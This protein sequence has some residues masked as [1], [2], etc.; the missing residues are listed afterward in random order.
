MIIVNYKGIENE[1]DH[2][3]DVREFIEEKLTKVF[4]HCFK[5]KGIDDNFCLMIQED[6]ELF[7]EEEKFSFDWHS[8]CEFSDEQYEAF[9]VLPDE[10]D[11]IIDKLGISIRIQKAP[12]PVLKIKQME[13]NAYTD[14]KIPMPE[15]MYEYFMNDGRIIQTYFIEVQGRQAHYSYNDRK[16]EDPEPVTFSVYVQQKLTQFALHHIN[17]ELKEP[18][19][20]HSPI[21]TLSDKKTGTTEG[22]KFNDINLIRHIAESISP[23]ESCGQKRIRF[24]SVLGRVKF[25]QEFSKLI[26]DLQEYFLVV[27]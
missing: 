26:K 25:A 23:Y 7:E 4:A 5:K 8:E 9:K 16:W 6:E 13:A 24:E 27:E 11:D 14:K 10:M 22:V 1:F 18:A 3:S 17:F 2:L 15:Y 12:E 19:T 20:A 21:M